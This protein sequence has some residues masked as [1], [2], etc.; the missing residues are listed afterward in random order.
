MTKTDYRLLRDQFREQ[1]AERRDTRVRRAIENTAQ[2]NRD[3]IRSY[4]DMLK[5]TRKGPLPSYPEFRRLPMVNTL[6]WKNTT[7][8]LALDG[9][10]ET[11]SAELREDEVTRNHIQQ[12]IDVWLHDKRKKLAQKL[13][14][15]Y[16]SLP[17]PSGFVHPV[18]RTTAWFQCTKCNRVSKSL[19][20]VTALSF[21]NVCAHQCIGL[22]KKERLQGTWD[23]DWFEPDQKVRDAMHIKI[24]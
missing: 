9:K 19:E 21:A 24:A 3:D 20:G 23:V 14:D 18:E 5:T 10:K 7:E 13:G 12:N 17:V 4:W 11:V 22:P 2:K 8:A 1:V 15:P 6:V 16:P